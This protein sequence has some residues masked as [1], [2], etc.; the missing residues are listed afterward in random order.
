ML[1]GLL[2]VVGLAAPSLAASRVCGP[3]A[4]ASLCLTVPSGALSGE[5]T[6]SAVWSGTARSYT[7]EFRLAGKYLN[8]EYQSPYSFI[9]PT[10]KSLDGMYRLRARVHEGG[11]EGDYV[12]PSCIW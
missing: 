10:D 5:Q 6:V 12:R 1:A 8:Y 9:W 7:V 3:S 4:G 2:S 11:I